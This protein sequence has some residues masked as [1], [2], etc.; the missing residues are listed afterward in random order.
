LADGDATVDY[1]PGDAHVAP[2]V[3]GLPQIEGYEVLQELGRGG[4]GVVYKARQLRPRRLVALKM[5]LAAEYAGS[6]HVARFRAEAEAVAR[7]QHPNIV[8]IHEVGD[9][10]GHAFL[11]LEYLEGGTLAT[12]LAGRQMS[13]KEA[14][15][16]VETLARAVDHA[17]Q[18]G[19]VHR[20]LKPSNVLF[21]AE[22]ELKVVDFGLAKQVGEG[23]LA[24][25]AAKTR[26]GAILGTPGYMAPEQA[27]GKEVGPPT[28]VY[29]LGAIL[30]EA[31]TGRAPFASDNT[32]DTLLQV[33][34]ED[35]PP[36]R[37]YR[38]K[39]SRDLE[40]IC[41]KCL[42][43]EPA[44]RYASAGELAADLRAF[45]DG[46]PIKARRA[47]RLE[48][49]GRW[50]RRRKEIAY[51]VLG[52]LAT[53]CASLL[54]LGLWNRATP[55]QLPATPKI[56]PDITKSDI[57]ERVARLPEDLRFV[58]PDALAFCS[59][60]VGDLWVMETTREKPPPPPLPPNME[61]MAVFNDVNRLGEVVK[62]YTSVHLRDVERA[63]VVL[64]DVPTE[65]MWPGARGPV[66]ANENLA[67][68][69]IVRLSKPCDTR[70]V[71]DLFGRLGP[72]G[73]TMSVFRGG[74]TIHTVETVGN[75]RPALCFIDPQLVLIAYSERAMERFLA[76]HDN[77]GALLK[78]TSSTGSANE[79]DTTK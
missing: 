10:Q 8:Q 16:L 14:A 61:W 46:A 78:R 44:R 63:T 41:L 69:G 32:F 50:V 72:G 71:L 18:K 25:A 9:H 35:P 68:L 38:P 31:L 2:S 39:L 26:T 45:L 40:T 62:E 30:Y 23:S 15:Q 28:D 42:Q 77:V 11:T 56:T 48:R 53:A 76:R 75:P 64:L 79:N 43:K 70:K 51:L 7:L 58:P 3:V 13:W 52:S 74:R 47:G 12:K 54:A 57:A 37:H 24:P 66:G 33:V 73:K 59:M 1:R 27:S 21:T 19:I 34:R 20:D 36:P 60:R 55:K 49:F 17:H 5:I 4:M 29:A 22:G 6:D 67:L 65:V